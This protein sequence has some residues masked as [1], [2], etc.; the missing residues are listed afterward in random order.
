MQPPQDGGESEVFGS[1]K[2]KVCKACLGIT[3]SGL[4][5]VKFVRLV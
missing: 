1:L 3:A 5:N 2:S 4:T